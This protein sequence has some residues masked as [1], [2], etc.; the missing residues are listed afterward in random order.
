MVN[1]GSGL[2]REQLNPLSISIP[3]S[4]TPAPTISNN[5]KKKKK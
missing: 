4:L 2:P 3:I 1:E 5:Q